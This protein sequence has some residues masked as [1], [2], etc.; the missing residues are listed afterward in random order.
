MPLTLLNTGNVGGLALQNMGNNGSFSAV[1]TTVTDQL[2]PYIVASRATYDAA[3]DNT[4]VKITSTEYNNLAAGIQSV[5]KV[6]ATDGQVNT[7]LVATAYQTSQTSDF[8]IPANRYIF[9]MIIEPWNTNC[10]GSVGYTTTVTGS[11]ANYNTYFANNFGSLTGGIRNYF[12]LKK[13][14]IVTAQTVYPF[15]TMSAS[16]NGMNYQSWGWTGTIWQYLPASSNAMAKFQLL[17]TSIKQW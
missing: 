17:T 11:I 2:R 6:G 16:P 4:W 5:T 14:T 15:V 9:G 8:T 12:V 13:P 3:A 10:L 7:R 1:V